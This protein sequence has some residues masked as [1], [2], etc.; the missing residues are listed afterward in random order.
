MSGRLD[1][2]VCAAV[3]MVVGHKRITSTAGSMLMLLLLLQS[4]VL[5]RVNCR[6]L[7]FSNL[8]TEH[9]TVSKLILSYA[10]L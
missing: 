8:P 6:S 3:A 1:S 2:F 9:Q 10:S 7:P 4:V 5:S